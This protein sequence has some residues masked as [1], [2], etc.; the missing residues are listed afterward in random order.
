MADQTTQQIRIDAPLSEIWEV[1]TDFEGY[2]A[3]AR[4]I[5]EVVVVDRDDEGRATAV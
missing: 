2:P 1:L 4:D 3:W 5:K